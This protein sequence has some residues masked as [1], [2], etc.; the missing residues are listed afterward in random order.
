MKNYLSILFIIVFGSIV[1]VLAFRGVAGNPRAALLQQSINDPIRPYGTSPD[2]GRYLLTQNLVENHSF[3]LTLTQANAAAPDV[4][5]FEGRWYILYPPGVAILAIPFY[6][7]GAH[8]NLAYIFTHLMAM[9]FS[10][11]NLVIIYLISRKVLNLPNWA[12]IFSSLIF[13][14]GSVPL[15]YST[16]LFQHQETVFFMLSC[17]LAVYQYKIHTKWGFFWGMYAWLAYGIAIFI[18]YPNAVMMLPIIIYFLIVSLKIDKEGEGYSLKLRS[19]LII[20]SVIFVA[21][22]LVHGYYNDVNFGGWTKLSSSLPSDLDNVESILAETVS[23]DSQQQ[24]NKIEANKNPVG[25]FSET[26]LM[27][28]GSILLFA[29]EKG[30]FIFSPIYILAVFGMYFAF[31]KFNLE[32]TVLISVVAIN[33]LLYSSW[34]DPWGGWAFGPRYLIPS[35]SILAI[36]VSLYLTKVRYKLPSKIIAFVLF[37]ASCMIAVSGA[38]TTN[39]VPPKSD[40]SLDH[41]SYGVPYDFSFLK[42]GQSN[43]YLF[44]TYFSNKITLMHYYELIVVFILLGTIVV[45]FVLPRFEKFIPDEVKIS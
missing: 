5:Y 7:V 18:D 29:P 26:Y 43:S 1:F 45:L 11:G 8:Y 10:L 30:L 25:F 33:L 2:R 4:G 16:T 14:V 31:K 32:K 12:S 38:L 17:F 36:F 6:I 39:A 40:A 34:G 44:N 13:G 37:A 15:S 35:M 9:L 24:L 21:L 28:S 27:R 41:S 22:T 42:N 3:A 23:S 20:T 19:S